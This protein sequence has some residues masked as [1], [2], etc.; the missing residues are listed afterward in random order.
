V[1]WPPLALK[2]EKNANKSKKGSDKELKTQ[3]FTV[4]SK[5]LAKNAKQFT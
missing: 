2:I 3:H 1:I 5:Q 4:I